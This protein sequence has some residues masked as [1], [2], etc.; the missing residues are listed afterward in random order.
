MISA[1]ITIGSISLA[2]LLGKRLF[3]IKDWGKH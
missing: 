1:A 2:L 3:N